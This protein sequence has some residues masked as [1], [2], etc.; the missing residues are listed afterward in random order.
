MP[1]RKLLPLALALFLTGLSP[2]SPVRSAEHPAAKASLMPDFQESF[3]QEME[4]YLRQTLGRS[5]INFSLNVQPKATSVYELSLPSHLQRDTL[6][7]ITVDLSSGKPRLRGRIYSAAEKT[8]LV[9]AISLAYG[10]PSQV[11]IETFPFSA[12]AKDYAITRNQADLYVKPQAV[13]G[14]NLATQARLGTPVQILDYSPD[15]KFA[16]VRIEDDGYI[17]WIQRKDLLEGEQNWYNDWLKHRQVLIMHPV[18]QPVALPVGTRLKLLS[19]LDSRLTAALPDGR[20]VSLSKQDV[21]LNT[22]GKLPTAEALLKTARYYLPKAP[23]GGGS[24]LWGGTYGTR[25]DCSGFVQT[26]YRLNGVYLPR[27]ADQQKGFTQRVGNTLKQMNELKPG[28]LVFFSGNGKYPTHV[29]LYIGNNQV[30]HS[31]PKGPYSGV[32]ISTLSGGG[33]YDKF[34]Q[35]IY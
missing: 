19:D 15:R 21:V 24:Y 11:A 17:A 8:L 28:D 3:N 14:D 5:P 2:V 29:G 31:S 25:L 16:L 32:K 13:A 27:D 10:T 34:L 26:V 33:E 4:G 7:H 20:T 23:Q 12:I 18:S 1:V 9:S 30:I 35:K 22:P 6:L